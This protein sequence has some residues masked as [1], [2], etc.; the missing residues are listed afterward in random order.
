MKKFRIVK[1]SRVSTYPDGRKEETDVYYSVEKRSTS[2]L[3]SFL[4][5]P[6]WLPVETF[7]SI[8]EAKEYV[9]A[10]VLRSAI[11]TKDVEKIVYEK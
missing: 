1:R 7:Y 6:V 4:F 8:D 11:K 9:D 5:D 3:V 10:E 2:L